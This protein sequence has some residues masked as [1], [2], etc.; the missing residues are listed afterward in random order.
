LLDLSE[1]ASILLALVGF[2]LV[3]GSRYLWVGMDS[4]WRSVLTYVGWALIIL[5]LGT[6]MLYGGR[7]FPRT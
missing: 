6:K 5:G 2:G 3:I 1:K 4:F 7:Y